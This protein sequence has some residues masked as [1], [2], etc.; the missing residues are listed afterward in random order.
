MVS[1]VIGL[2]LAFLLEN[3]LKYGI[4]GFIALN[5]V[6]AGV[7]IYYARNFLSSLIDQYA[8]YLHIIEAQVKAKRKKK[9]DERRK[10]KRNS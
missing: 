3:G 5:I 10:L 1:L 9:K 8:G 2:L 4:Y 7:R 6:L